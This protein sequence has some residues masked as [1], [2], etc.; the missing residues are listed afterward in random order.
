M[1][2][3]SYWSSWLQEGLVD[4]LMSVCGQGLKGFEK[5]EQWLLLSVREFHV[6][7]DFTAGSFCFALLLSVGVLRLVDV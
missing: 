1:A 5:L 2:V 4:A 3:S 6:K 7:G